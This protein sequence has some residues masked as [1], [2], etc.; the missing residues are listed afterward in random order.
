MYT[1]CKCTTC[2]IVVFKKIIY[3]VKLFMS[4][5]ATDKL[6]NFLKPVGIQKK[7]LAIYISAIWFWWFFFL[8]QT[9][10]Y[11]QLISLGK[12]T[13]HGNNFVVVISSMI[14]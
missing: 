13:R 7:F 2:T 8:L 6:G 5:G 11:K 10:L 14:H 4:K 9:F 3:T 12:M 1:T